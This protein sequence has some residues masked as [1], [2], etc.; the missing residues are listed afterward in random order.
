MTVL[1]LK[2]AESPSLSGKSTLTYQIGATSAEQLFIRISG[3]SG[4][5]LYCKEWFDL[6]TI[7]SCLSSDSSSDPRIPDSQESAIT[8]GMMAAG[9]VEV[10]ADR[11]DFPGVG[12]AD[13][14]VVIGR[15]SIN[16]LGFVMAALNHLGLVRPSK[17]KPGK[18]MPQSTDVFRMEMAA[19]FHSLPIDSS[20]I[21]ESAPD[22]S[23]GTDE[24][25]SQ[26]PI[27]KPKR[28]SK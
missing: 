20:H 25:A 11:Q 9:G 26:S 21:D 7:E 28:K 10:G 22:S 14:R 2:T 16:T 5:G 27:A 19:L 13:L 17:H 6:S 24:I 3:N 4:G 15:R 12:P 1:V 23:S 8:G 18:F